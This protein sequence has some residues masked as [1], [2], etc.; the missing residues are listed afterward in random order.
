MFFVPISEMSRNIIVTRCDGGPDQN[1]S[2]W[3]LIPEPVLVD[4]LKDLSAKTILNV[5]E[6]CRRWNDISKANYL[7][8]M[9]FQRDFR[10]DKQIELK[11]GEL[12]VAFIWC[13]RRIISFQ[14]LYFV[15]KCLQY[16]FALRNFFY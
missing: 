9:I 7:W 3:C 10:V 12:C 15:C 11:P 1:Y 6:C 16:V 8:K 4:I 5:G 2:K 14:I 13:L